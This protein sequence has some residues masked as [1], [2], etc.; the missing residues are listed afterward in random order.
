MR[1]NT[2]L[3]CLIWTIGGLAALNL[4]GWYAHKPTLVSFSSHAATM[5]PNTAVCLCLLAGTLFCKRP[6]RSLPKTANLLACGVVLLALGTLL[7]YWTGHSLGI[8]LFLLQV[9]PDPAGGPLGRMSQ[10]TALA[11]LLSGS[12]L[13]ALDAMP[14]MANFLCGLAGLLSVSALVGFIFDAGRIL[15]VP[16]LRSMSVRTALDFAAVQAAYLLLRPSREPMRSLLHTTRHHRTGGWFIVGSC[17]LPLLLGWPVA[18]LY[19]RGLFDATFALA[20]LVVA[21]IAM[22][23][24]LVAANSGSLAEV[25]K[26]RDRVEQARL[27]L[28]AE[29]ARQ[30]AAVALSEKRAAQSEAQYRLITNALPALVSY[31]DR[32]LCYRRVNRTYEVWFGG[33]A[34]EIE[35]QTLASVLG[36]GAAGAVTPYLLS[37]LAGNPQQ[38][39]TQLQTLQG[40]RTVRVSHIPDLDAEG[41]VRGVVVQSY[42]VTAERRSEAALRR[43]EKLAAVGKLASSIAHEINNPLEAVTNLL[44]LATTSAGL[45]DEAREY[46][47]TA[48]EELR[49]VSAIVNQTLRFHKQTTIPTAIRAEE[50]FETVLA[51]Y[52][53]RLRGRIHLHQRHRAVAALVCLEGEIRQVLNNLVGNAIDAMQGGPGRLWVRSR[54]GTSPETGSAGLLI[55]VADTGSGMSPQT[56]ETIFEAFFTTKGMNG[57]GLGLWVSK[58]IIDRHQGS[59]RVRSSQ[60]ERGHGTVFRL[61]LP[62]EARLEV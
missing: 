46:M 61:F 14:M 40:E 10:G 26:R 24:W 22:Q 8:D 29:N 27:A 42:D 25:E 51:I 28:A 62:Y 41:S 50:L 35:G 45:S 21:L 30:H 39:E 23:A 55:T 36:A 4:L 15:G 3:L 19:R 44:Y 52:G 18:A 48:E 53:P 31:I 43:A 49:R 57:T 2:A 34:T 59:V 9:P 17:L 11:A 58:E 5:K 6:I 20:L 32:N 60:A 47:V 33:S 13:L 37:A 56:L 7:E 12:A 1:F 16:L 38:F 54:Q